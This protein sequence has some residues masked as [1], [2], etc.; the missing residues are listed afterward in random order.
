MTEG[1]LAPGTSLAEARREIAARFRAHGLETPELDARLLIGH[2]LG[3][4]HAGLVS[5]A[6]RALA[7]PEADRIAALVARRLRHEP[8]SRILGEKEF[9]SLTFKLS[10]ATLVPRPETEILVEAALAAIDQTSSRRAPLR[11]ADLGT[12][13]GAILLALLSEL[14]NAT[15]IG[16]DIAPDALATARD[17]AIALRLEE[18]CDFVLSDFTAALK[19]PFDLVVSNPP[20]IATLE[21]EMLSPDVRDHDPRA[22]LDGG[23]DGLACYRRIATGAAAVLAAEGLVAVEIGAGQADAVTGLFEAAG[24]RSFLPPRP[25]FAG[26]PRALVFQR[27]F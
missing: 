6:T 11:I 24:F 26:I 18:R 16:C 4:D 19:G 15:G 9:W 20:Y 3:L 12:G 13:S 5:N 17:N 14:P 27:L 21:L 2:A 25:D 8:V 22:A 7:A 23:A 1:R 10:P